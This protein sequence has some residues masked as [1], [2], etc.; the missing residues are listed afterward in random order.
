M[1]GNYDSN[2]EP[3]EAEGAKHATISQKRGARN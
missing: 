3:H 1:L 2:H